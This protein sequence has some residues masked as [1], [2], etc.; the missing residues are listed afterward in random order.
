MQHAARVS[1][2]D[3]IA[4][5][6]ESTKQV[7]QIRSFKEIYGV[8][9]IQMKLPDSRTKILTLNQSHCVIG[10]AIAIE[11]KRINGDDTWMFQLAGDL[12][13]LYELA[14]NEIRIASVISDLLESDRSMQLEILSD[15][16]D[17][18][19]AARML[20]KNAEA[21]TVSLLRLD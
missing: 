1:V 2:I 10:L 17:A 20:S 4:N 8:L 21:R 15:K 12:R 19:S 3:R 7:L 5:I 18:K 14:S 16:D 11:S 13:F 9:S 6:Q